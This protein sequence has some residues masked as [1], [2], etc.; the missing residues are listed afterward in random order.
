MAN[1]WLYDPG[2]LLNATG[3]LLTL[4][5][6]M[7]LPAVIMIVAG[8]FFWRRGWQLNAED[9]TRLGRMLFMFGAILLV[10]VLIITYFLKRV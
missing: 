7:V 9:K 1:T 3:A 5:D 8:G 2:P 4:L 6:I 10:I